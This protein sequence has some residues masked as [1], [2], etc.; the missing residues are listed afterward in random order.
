[1]QIDIGLFF[2]KRQW[3][4]EY[5]LLLNFSDL[6]CIF[7]SSEQWMVGLYVFID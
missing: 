3:L 1:M 6:N 5:S 2:I 7:M 4:S